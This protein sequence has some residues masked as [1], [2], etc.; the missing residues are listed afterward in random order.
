MWMAAELGR[1]ESHVA[2]HVLIPEP[3]RFVV[4]VREFAELRMPC[5]PFSLRGKKRVSHVAQELHFHDMDLLD[6]DA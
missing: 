5:L 3:R 1:R 4:V 2:S 6:G